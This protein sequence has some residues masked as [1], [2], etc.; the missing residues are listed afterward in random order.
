M[1]RTAQRYQ[2]RRLTSIRRAGSRRSGPPAAGVRQAELPETVCRNRRP[3]R[4]T[5]GQRRGTGGLAVAPREYAAESGV[6]ATGGARARGK[7]RSASEDIGAMTRG[8][9]LTRSRRVAPRARLFAEICRRGGRPL[10][11][12]GGM[13][14]DRRAFLVGAVGAAWGAVGVGCW[15]WVPAAG[16][17]SPVL[18]AQRAATL[19]ALVGSLRDAPHGRLGGVAGAP[20]ARRFGRWDAGRGGGERGRADAVLDAVGRRGVAGYGAL[21]QRAAFCRTRKSAPQAAAL[22]A[23]VDLAAAVCEPPP[24]ED[25]RPPA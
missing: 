23:A 25:E 1:E 2:D 8:W 11:E 5:D 18:S 21:A 6:G 13:A 17:G 12:T 22:A 3:N 15:R 10:G 14:I 4:R 7:R 16:A 24:A 19:R 9:V 20:A